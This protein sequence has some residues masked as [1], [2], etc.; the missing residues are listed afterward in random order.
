MRTRAAVLFTLLVA[1]MATLA[2]RLLY[3]Q[4][5]RHDHYAELAGRQ[6]QRVVELAPPRG[7]IFDANGRPLAVSGP[8]D[9]IYA[10]PREIKDPT[11]TAIQLGRLLGLP[12]RELA[13]RLKGNG[14]FVWVS[15]LVDRDLAQ[16]VKALDLPGIGVKEENRRFYPQGELA[17]HVLGFVGTDFHGLAGLE[18]SFDEVVTGKTG[19][20][21]VRKDAGG[22]YA[23][24]ADLEWQDAEPGKDLHLTLDAS[25][26]YLAEREL[27][28][29]V[30]E[31][32]A[33]GGSVVVLDPK[34][35]AVLAMA[36]LP[37]FD[38]NRF[39][40]YEDLDRRGKNRV[41]TDVFEPGST[42]KM[43]T[44][45]AALEANLVDATDVFDCG[46][47]RFV[48]GNVTIRDHK[49]FGVLTLRDVIAK[50]SNV[51][52]IRVGLLAGEERL[53]N[54]IV[55]LGF[56]KK[57]GIELAGESAGL[58][59]P[60]DRWQPID[61]AYI[62]FGQGIAVTALQL[63]T[64]F[65]AVANG[66]QLVRPYLV[67]AVGTDGQ[68]EPTAKRPAVV[69][70][71]M[72]PATAL[73]VE[74]L[75]EAVLLEGG[76][77]H[78]SALDGYAL[79]GKTGTA[80][81]ADGRGYSATDHMAVFAG[82]GPG[83]DPRLAIAV[84]V[85]RPRRDYHGGSVAA[86]VFSAIV[87]QALLHQGFR[88]VREEKLTKWPHETK[89]GDGVRLTEGP[90][91]QPSPASGR[92]GRMGGP[93]PQPSPASGRGGRMG[94]VSLPSPPSAGERARVRGNPGGQP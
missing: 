55:S 1:F 71:A 43:V 47:G 58:L 22:R 10:V 19:R 62:S 36:S 56:G 12:A 17:A 24:D 44:V 72:S 73:R 27:G 13:A 78:A 46:L 33:E 42:F 53:W 86:P 23:F 68:R 70:R 57:T 35:G 77:A 5:M 14:W 85:D 11:G 3:L 60:R 39:N 15:R 6:Q 25:L 32:D 92:G 54:Q 91:P 4:V 83:R 9:S 38:P 61:K 28:R 34:T 16:Q 66:G 41:I 64:A 51:G 45:S 74:R 88:P 82:F 59:R 81:M 18:R 89:R 76:T 75:L 67:E 50:S 2:G 48:F 8:A 26:Q 21:V 69:G 84:V 7:T 40:D 79:A 20:R 80:Q 37:T 65:A 87:R 31:Y 30:E 90:S 49:S 29:A 94:Q 63:A 93:S 52:A